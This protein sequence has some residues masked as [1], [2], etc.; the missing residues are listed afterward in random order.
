VSGFGGGIVLE[1]SSDAQR[2]DELLQAD[3]YDIAERGQLVA[4]SER[5]DYTTIKDKQAAPVQLSEVYGIGSVVADNV[6]YGLVVGKGKDAAAVDQFYS[7]YLQRI[8]EPAIVAAGQVAAPGIATAP[9]INAPPAIGTIVTFVQMPGTFGVSGGRRSAVLACYGAREGSFPLSN[10]GLVVALTIPGAGPSYQFISSHLLDMLGTGPNGEESGAGPFNKAKRLYFRG[11]CGYNGHV[12]GWGYDSADAT[13]GE[14]P[15]RVMFS[16]LNRPLKWGNDNQA[17]VG[18]NRDFTDSD[19]I[20]VG[21]AG[22]IVRA[23]L[24]WNGK[25]W[26]GT[27]RELHYIAGFGRDSF[28]TDGSQQVARSFNVLGPHAMIEGPDK[29]LY[30]VG[31]QGLWGFDGAAFEPYFK[32][33]IDF[34][35][36]S[37]GYWNCIWTDEG[38]AAGYPGKTNQDLV[39][40]AVD[41]DREQVLIGIPFCDGARGFGAG[42]DTVVI[43][44]HT[45]SQ[46]FTRQVFAGVAFTAAGYFRRLGQ[47][48]DTRFLGTG[49]TGQK[50]IQRYGFQATPAFAYQPTPSP[51]MPAALPAVTF[52]EYAIYGPDGVGVYSGGD[53]TLSWEDSAAFPITFALRATVDG[54]SASSSLVLLTISNAAPGAPSN[55]DIWLD[56]SGS[57][58]NLGNLTGGA[59]VPAHAGTFIVK[60]YV[61]TWA[62]WVNVGGGGQQGTRATIAIAWTPIRGTRLKVAMTCTAAP[63]RFQV[64]G[65][66]IKPKPIRSA[67]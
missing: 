41:W 24:A 34:T 18:V 56:T 11:I 65:F 21:A 31:D 30:G 52:G 59:I 46:G 25:L 10:A 15:N 20:V 49:T 51:A 19:A 27:N 13:N 47:Q 54:A 17:A 64:E 26:L 38:A 53:L 39:W 2:T 37:T 43:K 5:S 8:G 6:P 42:S 4:T 60:R 63:S 44:F 58:T 14:G 3:G 16:N 48:H 40:M 62:K 1:G 12:F 23:G 22:E 33:L 66:A 57:D 36:R 45:R 50:T 29:L 7:A 9:N 28:L 61:T 32:R 35:G 55:G 67:L